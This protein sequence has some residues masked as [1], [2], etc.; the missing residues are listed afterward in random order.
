MLYMTSISEL[1]SYTTWLLGKVV[2]HYGLRT[3]KM[4]SPCS[5]VVTMVLIYIRW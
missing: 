2:S 3:D 5:G 4:E 1:A